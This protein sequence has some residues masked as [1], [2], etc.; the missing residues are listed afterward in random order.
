MYIILLYFNLNTAI[1]AFGADLSL[2]L[3]FEK[4]HKKFTAHLFIQVTTFYISIFGCATYLTFTFKKRFYLC[5]LDMIYMPS[6]KDHIGILRVS[7][8]PKAVSA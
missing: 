1:Q 7:Y 5:V 3:C 2:F 4:D 6:L 8:S